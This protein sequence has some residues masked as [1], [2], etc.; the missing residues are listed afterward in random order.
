MAVCGLQ[1]EQEVDRRN[2]GKKGERFEQQ[3]QHDAHGRQDGDDR[4]DHQHRQDDPLHPVP[5]AHGG[6]D[7]PVGQQQPDGGEQRHGRRHDPGRQGFQLQIPGR[8]LLHDGGDLAAH[9]IAGGVVP[10][11]VDEKF[12]LLLG[13]RLF[14]FR[15]AQHA[16][17]VRQAVPHDALDDRTLERHPEQEQQEGRKG[18]PDGDMGAVI[19]GQRMQAGPAAVGDGPGA[20]A[21]Q[22][23]ADGRQYQ[24]HCQ[25]RAVTHKSPLERYSRPP[26]HRGRKPL[27]APC[28]SA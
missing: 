26:I 27:P 25:D 21:A 11:I 2:L 23:E 9:D 5:R 15:L 20:P 12:F 16:H 6:R 18:D 19:A 8:A 10:D 22:V 24:Q 7:A 13:Q 4:G 14:G 1:S 17:P 3:R 28:K